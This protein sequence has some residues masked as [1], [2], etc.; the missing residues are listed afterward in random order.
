MRATHRKHRQTTGAFTLMELLIVISIMALLAG[1][2]AATAQSMNRAARGKKAVAQIAAMELG[3]ENYKGDYGEYPEPKGDAQKDFDGGSYNVGG[4]R[5]LYQA[6]SGDGADAIAGAD[7]GASNGQMG[8]SGDGE[9]YIPYLD[10]ENNTQ[11]MV[12]SEGEDYYLQDP[13]GKPYQYRKAG[14]GKT[15][16]NNTFDLWSFGTK[17]VTPDYNPEDHPATWIA[18]W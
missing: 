11:N 8:E 18:N 7:G 9:V 3:L 16:R 5:M 12:A 17:E 10:P 2:V 4:A 6:L 1:L 15:T 13:F 14:T